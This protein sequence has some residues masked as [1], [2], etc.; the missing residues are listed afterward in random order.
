MEVDM[1][2]R[3]VITRYLSVLPLVGVLAAWAA[4]PGAPASAQ[5]TV[6]DLSQFGFPKVTGMVDFTPGT[7]ATLTA[8]NQKVILPADFISTT[9]KFEFLEGDPAFFASN[10]AGDDKGDQVV[11]TFAFR[12]TNTTTG[13]LVARFDKPVVWSIT[14]PQIGPDSEVYNSTAANPPVITANPTK[15]VVT[16]NTLTHSFGGAGV[17]WLVLNPAEAVAEP[18]ATAVVVAPTAIVAQPTAVAVEEPTPGEEPTA[19]IVG[20]PSTGQ[21]DTTLWTILALAGM[22]MLTAGWFARRSGAAS[23]R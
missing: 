9:V 19:V 23:K 13:N 1:K 8:G 10:L 7:E 6:P 22:S 21:S 11:A 20:M 17:G 2:I 18:S 16:G 15:G 5:A 3:N 4:M 12:V 14:D